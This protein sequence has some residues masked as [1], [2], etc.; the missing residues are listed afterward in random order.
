[1]KE[2]IIDGEPKVLVDWKPTWEPIAKVSE[3]DLRMLHNK[4]RKLRAARRRRKPR[5][6]L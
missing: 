6:K 4:K 1:M 5:T 3:G 2:S